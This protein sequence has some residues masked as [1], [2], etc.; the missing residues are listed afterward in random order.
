MD[1]FHRTSHS[2]SVRN[3][4]L[5]DMRE[6]RKWGV[7]VALIS[8]SLDD[9]DS[10]MIDFAT[11]IFIMDAGP[12]QSIKKSS[13]VFGLPPSAENALR[14]YVRGPSEGG[15]TMLAIFA[16]KDG[17]TV[18]LITLTL[19]PIEL[20]AFST[21][22]EDSA[23]RNRLYERLGPKR[24]REVLS[25]L[26]PGGTAKKYFLKQTAVKKEGLDEAESVDTQGMV[27]DLVEKIIKM[28]Q[29]SQVFTPL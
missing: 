19:G 4:V 16:T 25:K 29:T 26:F 15:A 9:F 28:S 11:S 13:A 23:V 21:T 10:I 1:E 22:A 5:Q 17:T 12:E 8:Q 14:Q 18:Q 3:Q 7:Q 6:G 2:T 20:W 24:T 27:D